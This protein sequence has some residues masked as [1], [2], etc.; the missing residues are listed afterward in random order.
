MAAAAARVI[1]F[2]VF[3]LLL[4]FFCCRFWNSPFSL[5][6]SL[7]YTVGFWGIS[8]L[9]TNL[10]LPDLLPL[11]L[12]ILLLSLCGVVFRHQ[13]FAKA[14]SV[15]SV[16]LSLFF[17][18]SSLIQ[19]LGFWLAEMLVFPY[20]ILEYGDA[21]LYLAELLLLIG[22]FAAVRHVF[23]EIPDRL[24]SP[25]LLLLAV[26]MAFI[27]FV[28]SI[29]ISNVYGNTIIWKFPEG[30]I[31]PQINS[32][33]IVL[34]HLLGYAGMF[35]V[36]IIFRTLSQAVQK[37]QEAEYLSFQ[38]E[39]QK[40]YLS[41]AQARYE[42]ACAF[43]HDIQNHLIL[44]RELLSKGELERAEEYLSSLDRAAGKL[45][46]P[47]HSGNPAVDILLEN[48]FLAASQFEIS[49][50]CELEIPSGCPVEDM[51]WC[52]IL[53]NGMDNA[54]TA[55]CLLPREDS[56]RYIHAACRKKGG[57]FLLHIE[58]GCTVD[59]VPD[60]GTGLLNIRTAAEKY[61][62]LV[63]I[64]LDNGRFS[65]DVLLPLSQH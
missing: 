28:E 61:G 6:S 34:L 29:V 63:E 46:F 16:I 39:Q 1:Y 51:D 4:S 15:S 32:L 48:K 59:A 22:S 20:R 58:N 18:S 3:P 21:I 55:C 57:F 45:S 13:P 33:D 25:L 52:I 7:A 19:S 56:R 30:I 11:L 38:T 35:T 12:N 36:L 10:P 60:Y 27:S 14:L 42:K 43:R 24:E 5:S 64:S 23:G 44:L 54:I 37:G 50:E 65:L 41:E 31:Y 26:P 53:A 2:L 9:E 49:V 47:V 62:G 8:A 17:L 40:I